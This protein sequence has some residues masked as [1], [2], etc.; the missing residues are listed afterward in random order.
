VLAAALVLAGCSAGANRPFGSSTVCDDLRALLP[1]LQAAGAPAFARIELA[2]DLSSYYLHHAEE[3]PAPGRLLDATTAAGCPEV[4]MAVLT[5][6]D[7]PA[8]SEFFA[9]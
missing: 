5:A 4:R 3:R 8:F 7:E 2:I 6:I 1:R 9:Y